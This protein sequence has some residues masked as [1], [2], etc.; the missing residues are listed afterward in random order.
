MIV[1][2]QAN[3]PA[4]DIVIN[5]TGSAT[6]QPYFNF[7]AKM[8]E[9]IIKGDVAD[10][11][12]VSGIGFVDDLY[13]DASVVPIDGQYGTLGQAGPDIVRPNN[14]TTTGTMQFDVADLPD[15]VADGSLNS[16][17]LHEMG[18]VLG[19]GTLWDNL[20]LL[21]RIA[22]AAKPDGFDYR[23]TGAN[24]VAEY[25]LLSGNAAAT[26]VQ[27][28]SDQGVAGDGTLGS[29]WDEAIFGD[30]C[31]TGYLSGGLNPLSRMTLASMRDLGYVVDLGCADPFS[32]ASTPLAYRDDFSGNYNTSTTISIGSTQTGVIE[33]NEDNDWFQ[34]NLVAGTSYTFTMKGSFSGLGTLTDAFLRLHAVDGEIIAFNDN[35]SFSTES[36]FAFTATSSGLYYLDASAAGTQTGTYSLAAYIGLFTD[37]DDTITLTN[38]NQVSHALGGN[39][40]IFGSSGVDTIY[41]DGGNDVF[42]IA[43]GGADQIIGGTG[44]DT[45]NYSAAT[46]GADVSLLNNTLN[47]RAAAGDTFTEIEDVL[48]TKYADNLTGNTTNNKLN[49]GDGFNFSSVQG[50][51][52]R[53]YE[54]ALA[55]EPDAGGLLNWV[56]AIN[57]GTS[58]VAAAAGFVG[59]AEFT[60][61]Y[62][63]LNNT[64]FVT[65]LYANVL[66][67]APDAGGLANWVN[68]LNAGSSRASVLTGFSESLEFKNNTALDTS[69]YM[70]NVFETS[71]LG[72]VYRLYGASL[73]RAPD[74]GGF[75]AQLNAVASGLSLNSLAANFLNSTEFQITYGSL[76]N[77]AFV[78]KLYN[79]VLH[80]APEAAG[81]AN[82]VNYLNS[83]ATRVDVLLG[84][85]QS[86]EYVLNTDTSLHGFIDTNMSSL[87]SDR[88]VGG[89]GNDDLF[90][91]LGS[92]TFAFNKTGLG[93]DHIHGLDV[94]DHIEFTGFGYSTATQVLSHM[95]QVAT[96]V[97]FTDQ[98]ET[99]TFHNTQLAILKTQGVFVFA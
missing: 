31:L 49:G 11:N 20:G 42:Y 74:A 24:A 65:Q 58:L 51:V 10:Q 48:G 27:V 79:N 35:N 36:T 57:G 25:R 84:F 7:A 95:S 54:A 40:V 9:L 89:A 85:S 92:D 39:D 28:E 23:F 37:G 55:R 63:A 38:P 82:W 91:G 73:G 45:V 13:I 83:G 50:S 87:W 53:L 47:A 71:H 98:G 4:F 68:A 78:T 99:I 56:N 60:A 34:V 70:T 75:V 46:T 66:H 64:Q 88:L 18:H 41:G 3:A 6:Y 26:F 90:G 2:S 72:D 21:T 69:G 67:R 86:A 93:S 97:V 32:I 43:N 30:E 59:S 29:H 81:L 33:I 5:Y 17:I 16:V 19:I 15:L 22:N 77:T 14:I 52:Y 12:G 44:T 76:S 96:D 62:G 94:F 1:K 80:R 61:K 8:W